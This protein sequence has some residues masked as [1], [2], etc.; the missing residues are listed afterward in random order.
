MIERIKYDVAVIGGSLG[1]VQAALSAAKQGKK[2]Y[3]CEQTDWVGGQLTSQAVPPDE[4]RWIEQF[5]ATDSYL[6]YR[7]DVR[8][9]YR[10]LPNISDEIKHKDSFCPGN[11]WVSRVAHEPKVA[12]QILNSYLAP[13]MESGLIEIDY[14]TI[15]VDSTVEADIISSV[16]VMNTVSKEK[17]LIEAEYFLDATDCGDLLPL[18]HA[19]YRTGAESRAETGELH[20]PEIAD[21]YDMQPITW[22]AALELNPEVPYRIEKPEKYEFFKELNVSYDDNKL[23]SW[24]APDAITGK[25]VLFSMF[26]HE[27]EDKPLGLWSYRRIIDTKNYKDPSIKEVSLMNIPQNDF[28]LGNIYEDAE[29]DTNR[30][31]A[32]EQTMCMVY[33]L[34][35]DAPRADGK[36]GYPVRLRPDIMGT[37]D[38]LAK[39]PYIRES[40]RIVAMKTICEQDVS[41]KFNEQ[42]P[43]CKD[44]VGIGHYAVDIHLTTKSHT[45]LYDATYPFEIPLSAMIPVRLKN[46]LPACKNIGC[47]HLT[48][49]CYRLHPVEWN[50]G[51]V[52]GYLAALSIEEGC[53]PR[54]ILAGKLEKF[55]SLLVQQGITLHWDFDKMGNL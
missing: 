30:R 40:R 45:F 21:P 14:E 25:K 7:K 5:G 24:Y 1:G 32:K 33:W 42:P 50:V 18:V 31:L 16:T 28:Y 46:L 41:K 36:K 54:E 10:N 3:L 52:A 37:E 2:V 43:I 8:D 26:D 51:E 29:A 38:G 23:F 27:L 49:G 13:Y 17:K 35:N 39:A 44:S 9:Y 22:V 53:T 20:A 6:K 15:P 34:Q 4:H 11:S 48:N 12:L 55:Q 47:T 19:E